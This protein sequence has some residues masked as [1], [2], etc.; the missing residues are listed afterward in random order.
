M[1]IKDSATTHPWGEWIRNELPRIQL[2]SSGQKVVMFQP[3]ILILL[4]KVFIVF[5]SETKDEM[6]L[7]HQ[8]HY[9]YPSN[10]DSGF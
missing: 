4:A 7:L 3:K 8:V 5:E 10:I 2:E 9:I 6:I 1:I